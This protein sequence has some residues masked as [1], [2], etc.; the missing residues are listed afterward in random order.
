MEIYYSGLSDVGVVRSNN[1]DY[2]F[3]GEL[4]TDEYIFVVADG[5][6]GHRGGKIAS[7]RAVTQLVDKIRETDA[8]CSTNNLNH[9]FQDVNLDIYLANK[10]SGRKGGM[11]TTLTLLI[12]KEN[13]GCIAHVGDSRAYRYLP[14]SK[15]RKKPRLTQLTEDHSFVGRLLKNNLI[16]E[17]EA[18]NHPRRNIIY[19][20]IGMKAQV[21]IQIIP[22]FPIKKG[23]K[24]LLCSDGLHGVVPEHQ[25][26][27]SLAESST[28]RSAEQLIQIA[29]DN[30]G[31]D[32]ISVIVISTLP[33]E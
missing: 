29:K 26:S 31:P 5:M 8:G 24:Y 13:R 32:N 15:R 9:L 23:E 10:Q 33:E 21:D 19:Q 16:T 11:G 18:W 17:E 6:G 14:P 3:S 1:E 28:S 12:I 2:C 4:R 7:R 30:G 22:E 27:Q 25:I 20:S